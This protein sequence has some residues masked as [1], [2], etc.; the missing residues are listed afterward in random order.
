MAKITDKEISN[1]LEVGGYVKSAS[2][3]V[4]L[5]RSGIGIYYRHYHNGNILPCSVTPQ[6]LEVNDWE[7][8]IT[9][10]HLKSIA[11]KFR[12]ERNREFNYPTYIISQRITQSCEE[13]NRFPPIT[14]WCKEKDYVLPRLTVE[15]HETFITLIR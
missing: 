12:L 3:A 5:S 10:H 13:A 2:L 1:Y 15:Q 4:T 11:D 7:A 8:I 9:E 14:L 6:W